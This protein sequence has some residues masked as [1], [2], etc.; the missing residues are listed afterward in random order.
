M[1]EFD[2]EPA[3]TPL[4]W[5]P[6]PAVTAPLIVMV[7]VTF[8]YSALLP[9]A[10][11]EPLPGEPV[12]DPFNVKAPVPDTTTPAVLFAVVETPVTFP[13]MTA[14]VV[15]VT[16]TV[17]PDVNVPALAITFAVRVRPLPNVNFPVP[18]C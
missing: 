16:S 3:R 15:A 6:V 13:L 2:D 8:V 17:P 10:S 9:F 1:A 7:Q 4:L 5:F 12:T 11:E 14:V 18:A